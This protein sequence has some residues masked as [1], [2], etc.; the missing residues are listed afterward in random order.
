MEAY[1]NYTI[2]SAISLGIFT[3]A[4]VLLLRKE[5][6]LKA[7]RF[8]LLFA[9]LFS[10]VLPFLSIPFPSEK[11]AVEVSERIIETTPDESNMLEAITVYA[12]GIPAKVGKAIV[13]VKPSLWFYG[14]GAVLALFFIFS[15]IFQLFTMIA[16]NRSFRLKQARLV[17]TRNDIT[18]YSFFHFIF[19]SRDLPEQE[20]W[21]AM[22]KHELEHVRQGH[23]F[24]VLLIDFMMVFQ[25]F[26]PF[27]WIIRRMVRENHEFL[28][29]R[30]VLQNGIISPGRY[31]ALLLAQAVG[32]RLLMTSNFFNVKTIQ[33]RFKMMTNNK[34]RKY[35]FLKY[36][37][38][39]MAAGMVSL[40]F[41]A[42]NPSPEVNKMLIFKG[43]VSSKDALR[44]AKVEHVTVVEAD[45]SVARALYP[46]L[47][48]NLPDEKVRMAFE[49]GDPKHE[50]A[51][52]AIEPAKGG[53]DSI[54]GWKIWITPEQFLS[55]HPEINKDDF[56]TDGKV[57]LAIDEKNPKDM[58]KAKKLNL[59]L[60]PEKRERLKEREI[61]RVADD[62][63]VMVEDMP[64]FP[65]G[66]EALRKYLA[67][68]LKYPVIA[69]EKGIQGKVYVMFV[70]NEVG[71]IED[72]RVVRGI[73]P[74][75]DNEALRIINSSSMPAWK[76]GMQ[77]GKAVKVSYTV[78]FNFQLNNEKAEPKK[79]DETVVVGHKWETM[80]IQYPDSV[81]NECDEMPLFQGGVLDVRKYIAE[82]ILYPVEAKKYGIQG[83]VYVSF[84]V[85]KDGAVERVQISRSVYPALDNE[86]IRVVTSMPK[87]KPGTKAGN[88]VSVQYTLPVNFQLQ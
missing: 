5:V 7:S 40:C 57:M 54:M 29:D 18:P 50:V 16:R 80:P 78:P 15:G 19:I 42:G 47:K 24:D 68:N 25:W 56:K 51:V 79:I 3:L 2:E 83:K 69:A 17:I 61:T 4:Y 39:V 73:D 49:P 46:D 14:M 45:A 53:G 66:P 70:V 44:E 75:L 82:N 38:G 37:L 26:N 11:Q 13:S 9:V 41:A 72:A 85:A 58:E 71:K 6:L 12:S 63:Y 22:V 87:W 48:E 21:K 77:R 55:I 10:T 60:D 23:S 67:D 34:T 20:N 65:G 30:A 62:V 28:A 32:G 31:K 33:K 81:Y 59:V 86:A 88:P 52:R 1:F 8:F 35:S 27:Y 64:E 43:E 76:P 36:S 74:S 84:V